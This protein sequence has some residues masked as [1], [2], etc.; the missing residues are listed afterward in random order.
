MKTFQTIAE[1][2][3]CTGQEVAVSDWTT[4]TQQQVNLFADA[5][6]D[7]QWIHVDPER[8]AAGPFGAP[9]AHGFLTLSLIPKFFE[10]S[11]EVIGSRMGVNY[12]L[13]KVRFTAPVPVGSRLR[14]RMKL[15]AAEPV[16]NEGVQMT[17]AVTVEREGSARPVC[18]AE[19]LVRHYP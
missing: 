11:F 3:A 2:A 17:W 8:A 19:S 10:S 15:L 13:N 7:H 12:G 4:V 18:V 6:D 14:A 16:D 5:T 1:L 9:I